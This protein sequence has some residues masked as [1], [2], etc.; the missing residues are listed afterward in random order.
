VRSWNATLAARHPDTAAQAYRL[1]SAMMNTAVQDDVLPK[2]PCRV[3][4]AS[5][6]ENPERPV[7][8]PE[9]IAAAVEVTDGR[10]QLTIIL[11][12]WCHLRPEEILGL[13]R[14]DIDLKNS[15]LA[16]ERTWTSCGG[17]MVLGEPKT[18]AGYRVV[19][20]PE[21]VLPYL[22][23]HLNDYVEAEPQSWLFRGARGDT[24]TTRTLERHWAKARKAIGRPELRLYDMRHSGLTLAAPGASLAE[25]MRRGGQ[26]TPSAAL[27]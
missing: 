23:T 3:K 2:S 17:K 11:A 10:Y 22:T 16:I 18:D 9:E 15:R 1:L 26:S 21:N 14:G 5:Y 24:V 8:S 20:I 12:G 6:Y 27:R 25:L 4:G 13:Q 7:A 19:H